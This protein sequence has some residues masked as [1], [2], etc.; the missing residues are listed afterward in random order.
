MTENPSAAWTDGLRALVGAHSNVV[1]MLCG[2]LHR[3]LATRWA[4][5]MIAVCPP[6]AAQVAL[7]FAALDPEQPDSRA[8]I[9]AAPPGFAIHYWNGDGLVTHFADAGANKV[10]ARFD[11]GMQPLVRRLA[12]ERREREGPGA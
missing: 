3:P 7:D 11:A 2:H 5:T 12:M 8:M 1:G 6:T 10:L 4:G 9:V